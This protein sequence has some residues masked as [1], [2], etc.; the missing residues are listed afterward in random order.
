MDRLS[1]AAET[2]PVKTILVGVDGTPGSLEAVR[3]VAGLA[4]AVSAT[5]VMVTAVTPL[6]D[7]LR[8]SIHF[9]AGNWRQAL[10]RRMYRDWGQPLRERGV[11]IRTRLIERHPGAALLMVAEQEGADLI[12]VG[13]HQHRTLTGRLSSFLSQRATCPVIAVPPGCA[14]IPLAPEAV[15]QG[16]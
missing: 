1:P 16:A 12:V 6:E 7:V 3:W 9:S 10:R 5:V 15:E 2:R 8:D 11:P 14:S 4:D 13:V